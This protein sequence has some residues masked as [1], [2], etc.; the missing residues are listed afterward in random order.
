MAHKVVAI[1]FQL[2]MAIAHWVPLKLLEYRKKIG[3]STPLIPA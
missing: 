2:E 1:F 3:A